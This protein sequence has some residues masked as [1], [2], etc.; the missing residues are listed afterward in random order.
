MYLNHFHWGGILG[1]SKIWF[2]KY[3]YVNDISSFSAELFILFSS[4]NENQA[5]SVTKFWVYCKIFLLKERFS[6]TELKFTLQGNTAFERGFPNRFSI[7]P[8]ILDFTDTKFRRNHCTEFDL[9]QYC[10][11]WRKIQNWKFKTVVPATTSDIP[12]LQAADRVYKPYRNLGSSPCGFAHIVHCPNL[13]IL[14]ARVKTGK[15]L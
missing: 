12:H 10:P 11:I 6:I 4:L 13:V 3:I 15:H 14:K 8:L 5:L 9:Q 7:A 1:D 2:F